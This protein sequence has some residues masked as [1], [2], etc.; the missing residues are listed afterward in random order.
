MMDGYG[1]RRGGRSHFT[2]FVKE[3]TN[4]QQCGV[5]VST[6]AKG[7]DAQQES[8]AKRVGGSSASSTADKK[9]Q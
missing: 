7:G 3:E 5:R 1:V 6:S 9:G 8:S 2:I 4:E